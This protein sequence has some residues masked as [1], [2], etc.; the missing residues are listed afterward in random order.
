MSEKI[1]LSVSGLRCDGCS[2]RIKA[3]LN[4]VEGVKGVE[5]NSGRKE[6]SIEFDNAV[7]ENILIDKIKTLGYSAQKI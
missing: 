2:N 3:A 4:D 1:M 5:V 7:E 6:V